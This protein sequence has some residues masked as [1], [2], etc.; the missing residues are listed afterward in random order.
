M[1]EFV[2]LER[3]DGNGTLMVPICACEWGQR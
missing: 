1:T 3:E 2:E